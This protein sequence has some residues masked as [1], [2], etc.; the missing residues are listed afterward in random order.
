MSRVR[1][2][3]NYLEDRAGLYS[4]SLH[5]F[6]PLFIFVH[7]IEGIS[8]MYRTSKEFK[9]KQAHTKNI[10]EKYVFVVYKAPEERP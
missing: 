5:E 9:S 2:L 10:I 8:L 4:S 1:T 7:Y 3:F 6:L